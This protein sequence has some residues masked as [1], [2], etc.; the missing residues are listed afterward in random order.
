M[1]GE[2]IEDAVTLE[3]AA[4][5]HIVV[6][7][8]IFAVFK[9]KRFYHLLVRPNVKLALLAFRI[10]IQRSRERALA[11]RHLARKPTDSFACALTEQLIAAALKRQSQ[12]FKQ[13]RVVVKHLLEM[14][15]EPLLVHRVT[16]ETAPK[17]IVNAAL[18]HALERM[19]DCLEKAQ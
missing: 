15:H 3:I 9:A 11:R 2:P 4:G 16:R 12:Q 17:V 7:R 10:G 13:L 19:L 1:A 14:R 5:S 18:A 6:A 8:K